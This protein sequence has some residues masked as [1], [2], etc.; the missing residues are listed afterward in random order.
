MN[1]PHAIQNDPPDLLETLVFSHTSDRIPLD[2]DVTVCQQLNGLR[3][4]IESTEI[5]DQTWQGQ[6]RRQ[7][8][9]RAAGLTLS[10]LPPG[11]TNLCRR[12][13][14]LS[15]FLTVPPILI[16]SHP[17]P[18]SNTLAAWGSATP[19]ASNLMRS[20]DERMI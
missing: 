2:E 3:M 9:N 20:R 17:T 15:L 13:T 7:R 16:T 5:S 12:F 14:N 11:P 10:V 6:R 4:P 18:S 1:V 8:I 19:R